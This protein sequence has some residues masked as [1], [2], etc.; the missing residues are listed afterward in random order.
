MLEAS[1]LRYRRLFESA[2]D[3]ILLLDFGTGK[4]MDVNPFLIDLLGYSKVDFLDKFLWEIGSFKD[5]I[6]SKDNFLTLQ[7]KDYIRYENLP[8]E[9]KDGKK[10]DVEFISNVY[11]V[12]SRKTIQCNIR[13]ITGQN[14]LE[15]KLDEAHYRIKK[16]TKRS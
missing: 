15:K 9:T 7:T 1:E 11:D 8:L 2:K 16:R 3:G 6:Q 5:L 12:D 10:I 14:R 4:I 13:D